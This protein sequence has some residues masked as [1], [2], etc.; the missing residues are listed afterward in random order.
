MLS[1]KLRV[2]IG[3]VR[4]FFA[5][6]ILS[7]AGYLYTDGNVF[8]MMLLGPSIHLANVVV[9]A[10][11]STLGIRVTNLDLMALLPAAI[12]YFCFNGFLIKQLLQEKPI[13]RFIA[14]SCLIGFLAYIHLIA[15]KN[16][17]SYLG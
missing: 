9:S 12:I 15:W 10:L 16:L 3:I 6:G 4:Y 14:L 13:H 1:K 8:F 11:D 17:S 5:A 7:V 2:Q